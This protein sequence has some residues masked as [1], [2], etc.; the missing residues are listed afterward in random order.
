MV[1]I[2][3]YQVCSMDYYCFWI[4]KNI[5]KTACQH[6]TLLTIQ[7]YLLSSLSTSPD[8]PHFG[9]S[10]K[11]CFPQS[12]ALHM[13]FLLPNSSLLSSLTF[14]SLNPSL[15]VTFSREIIL[16]GSREVSDN[17]MFFNCTEL[18]SIC[19]HVPICDC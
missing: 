4:R 1:S 11:T 6:F 9:F 13:L 10:N 15:K 5:Y 18:S 14:C 2:T 7:L 17:T 12:W 16:K 19:S 3:C 8:R